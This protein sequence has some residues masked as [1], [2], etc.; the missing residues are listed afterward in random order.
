MN[1]KK[2]EKILKQR[3]EARERLLFEL[4][5]TFNLKEEYVKKC[6][7]QKIEIINKTDGLSQRIR[8]EIISNDLLI[9]K[10]KKDL[11]IDEEIKP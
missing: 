8:D 1:R 9:K 2:L 6:E 10:I 5:D 3:L 4:K 7:E 11:G